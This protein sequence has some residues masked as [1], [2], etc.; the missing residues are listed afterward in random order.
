MILSMGLLYGVYPPLLP[1]MIEQGWL[2]RSQAGY[3][4][5]VTS[6]GTLVGA[7]ACTAL[8]RKYNLGIAARVFLLIGLASLVLSAIKLGPVWLGINRFAAGFSIAGAGMTAAT[9]ITQGARDQQRGRLIALLGLG[10]GFGSIM[11]AMTLP[12]PLIDIKASAMNGWLY[13]AILSALCLAIA[14]PGLRTRR[15]SVEFLDKKY[16]R[17]THTKRLVILSI[18]YGTM[19]VAC[20]PVF[21][22]LSTYI[23]DEHKASIAFSTMA[24]AI[25]GVGVASGG[26]ICN[27]IFVRLIGRYASLIATLVVGL[28]AAL[29]IIFTDLLW[30]DLL[31]SFL[32]ALTHSGC[33][34]LRT[35]GVLKLAGPAGEVVW[36]K[37]FKV[38]AALSFAAGSFTCGILLEAELGYVSLFIMSAIAFGLAVVTSWFVTLPKPVNVSIND[39]TE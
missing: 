22:Y 23:H 1:A 21:V 15:G 2:T 10:A 39:S 28:G 31:A 6:I 3:I 5:A 18:C 11:M 37:I 12:F 26:Y 30:V 24:Y 19:T 13:A 17:S 33:S 8:G 29:L 25:T 20:T 38:I 16:S 27:E 4:A 36:L 34:A 7:F 14:W 35:H 9:L 32:I